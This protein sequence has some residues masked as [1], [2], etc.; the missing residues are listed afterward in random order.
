MGTKSF[1]YFAKIKKIAT[2]TKF[3]RISRKKY[4]YLRSKIGRVA[5]WLGKALQKPLLRFESARDLKLKPLVIHFIIGF[6]YGRFKLDFISN[7][8]CS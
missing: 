1:V 6:F 3:F 8:Q 4:L 7:I 2:R 5:E